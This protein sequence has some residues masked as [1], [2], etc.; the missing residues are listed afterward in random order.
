MN[1]TVTNGAPLDIQ[2][3]ANIANSVDPNT[4]LVLA[5]SSINATSNSQTVAS[6]SA[7]NSVQ[8]TIVA[9]GSV[10]VSANTSNTDQG[11]AAAATTKK[12]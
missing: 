9:A 1:A 10:N 3:K 4:T 8:F 7:I 6:P 2:V 12:V 5:L 11:F